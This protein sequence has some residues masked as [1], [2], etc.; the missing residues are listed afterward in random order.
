MLSEIDVSV[1]VTI[2]QLFHMNPIKSSNAND[3]Y[4]C[5]SL[6]MVKIYIHLSD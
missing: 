6:I 4:H 5:V 3:T 2:K 1:D